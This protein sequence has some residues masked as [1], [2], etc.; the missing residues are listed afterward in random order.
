MIA[1]RGR[2]KANARMLIVTTSSG[3]AFHIRGAETLKVRQP[4]VDS[5]NDGTTRR[6]V[7]AER[8]A[9]RPGISATRSRYRGAVS[10]K[11]LY[12]SMAAWTSGAS[13]LICC[14]KLATTTLPLFPTCRKKII[15][16][17]IRNA[18]IMKVSF[19]QHCIWCNCSVSTC[20]PS[21]G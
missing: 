1:G 10:W 2:F 8:I 21:Y 15:H 4:T 11:T 16:R 7:L 14:I 9:R 19:I 5:L 20:R 3:S 12:V 17:C 6:L 13:S 18:Q